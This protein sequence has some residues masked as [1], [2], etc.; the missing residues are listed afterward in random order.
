MKNSIQHITNFMTV[1]ENASAL[2]TKIKRL[3]S[4]FKD[5]V[6]LKNDEID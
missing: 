4:E 3:V 1:E 6:N 5:G 2:E